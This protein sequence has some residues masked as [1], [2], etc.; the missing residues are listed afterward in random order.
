MDKLEEA[1]VVVGGDQ[2]TRVRLEGARRL[3][4][5]APNPLKRLE[6]FHPIVT[7]IWHTKQDLLE[8]T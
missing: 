6:H 5:H 8:V 3:R 4:S 1:G 2:L 7:E